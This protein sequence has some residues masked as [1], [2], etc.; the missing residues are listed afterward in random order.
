MRE[1]V[2]I[3]AGF[4]VYSISTIVLLIAVQIIFPNPQKWATC[5]TT[6]IAIISFQITCAAVENFSNSEGV[7][8]VGVLIAIFWLASLGIDF[9]GGAEEAL[10]FLGGGQDSKGLANLKEL[11]E[12]VWNSKICAGVSVVLALRTLSK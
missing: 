6:A 9:F 5:I 3:P 10:K 11:I 7:K 8:I 2:G 4:F 1:T 12:A